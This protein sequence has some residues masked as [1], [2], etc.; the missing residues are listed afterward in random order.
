MPG[1]NLYTL[2]GDGLRFA[3]FYSKIHDRVLRPLL[4]AD[5][6]QAPPRLQAALHTIDR[7]ID[8]RLTQA[9]LANAT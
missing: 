7:H 8:Q 3:I 4:A 9:R 6:P 5:Q 1:R 2:T